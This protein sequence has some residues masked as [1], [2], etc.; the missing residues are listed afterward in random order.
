M[1]TLSEWGQQVAKAVERTVAER[2]CHPS[3][4]YRLQ[5]EHE[6][7]GF[8]D[9]AG[10][11]SYLADLGVSHLYASPYQKVRSGSSH[12]YAIVDY[13]QL[14]PDLGDALRHAAQVVQDQRGGVIVAVGE[15]ALALAEHVGQRV[16][17]GR[18]GPV[19]QVRKRFT[20]Q[21]G[22]NRPGA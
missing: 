10:I 13:R 15:Q 22:G 7:M 16:G 11:A 9:A 5:F 3:A 4:T 6:K 14:D 17:L 20:G 18:L 21:F 1:W 12:G 2:F 8:R 19:G